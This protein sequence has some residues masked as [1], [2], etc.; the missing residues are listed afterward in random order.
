MS[1]TNPEAKRHAPAAVRNRDPILAVLRE[2]LPKRGMVLEIASG[3]GE[4]AVYFA[5]ALPGLTF[6]P[7][8]S[9]PGAM[10]SID[11][12]MV[13]AETGAGATNLLPALRL[14]AAV[15]NWPVVQADAVLCI[16]MVHIAP[17]EAALGLL[18]GAAAVLPP[19]APLILYG[20]YHWK[21][22]HTAPS[23]EAFDA[24]LRARNP[25][26]GVREVETIAE[27]ALARGFTGPEIRQMPANNLML[28]FRRA[29][30]DHRERD[31]VEA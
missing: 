20:P 8:D 29:K 27:A 3:S 7:T 30:V 21:G 14:D 18:R 22:R 6:Q 28:L 13:E 19:G 11:A 1:S 17:W 10:T 12:W 24:D 23:N 26:W 9:D 16:N 2:W 5:S 15:A 31:R 25:A 4:H